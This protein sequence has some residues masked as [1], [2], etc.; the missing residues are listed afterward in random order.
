MILEQYFGNVTSI[1]NIACRGHQDIGKIKIYNHDPRRTYKAIKEHMQYVNAI[2]KVSLVH[3][4]ITETYLLT[5]EKQ[6]PREEIRML[7]NEK[8]NDL[9]TK[10]KFHMIKNKLRQ[11]EK[12][13]L[14]ETIDEIKQGK[15]EP[16]QK[17]R[18]RTW[19]S[20]QPYKS[21]HFPFPPPVIVT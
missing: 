21:I 11:L 2:S 4:C 7:Y 18:F 15:G 19:N 20:A 16:N 1:T 13:Q 3:D 14:W 8:Y 9:A 10:E 5:L 17:T 6:L 12:F